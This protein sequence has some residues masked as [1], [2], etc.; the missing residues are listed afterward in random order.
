MA[1][2]ENLG[3]I[4]ET[5]QVDGKILLSLNEETLKGNGYEIESLGRRKRI[6]RAI[7]FL[8]A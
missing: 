1:A 3:L 8:K 4:F 5:N 7:N 6:V 2:I